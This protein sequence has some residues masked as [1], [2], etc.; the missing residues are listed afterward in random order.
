MTTV[1]AAVATIQSLLIISSPISYRPSGTFDNPNYAGHFIGL[2]MVLVLAVPPRRGKLIYLTLVP[3]SVA[4]LATGS[5][6]SI[7]FAVAGLLYVAYSRFAAL[8]SAAAKILVSGLFAC[9]LVFTLFDP[10]QI[11]DLFQYQLGE[12]LTETRFETSSSGR[13][14]IWSQGLALLNE[15]PLG[16][17]PGAMTNLRLLPRG[18]ELHSDYLGYLIERGPLALLG[19]LAFFGLMWRI[20]RPRSPARALLVAIMVGGIFRETLHFRHLWLMLAIASAL[21][22]LGGVRSRDRPTYA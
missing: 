5:F 14:E 1:V 7:M 20:H 12:G 6:G 16:V 10:P 4:L 3:M 17:G 22:A 13:G 15:D 21:T 8:Q 11:G 9:L 19:L 18:V 2:A